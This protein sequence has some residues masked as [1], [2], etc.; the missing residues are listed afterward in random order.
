[1]RTIRIGIVGQYQSG[2]SLL[3][4]CLL[5]RSIASV[6]NGTPTTH[7]IVH[8]IYSDDEYVEFTDI[9][10]LI[11]KKS[12]SSLLDIDNNN[13]ICNPHLWGIVGFSNEWGRTSDATFEI[14][15]GDWLVLRGYHIAENGEF[16][17]RVN[18]DWESNYGANCDS[19]SLCVS[20]HQIYT[21]VP[22]GKNLSVSSHGYYDVYFNKITHEL[23]INRAE[24]APVIKIVNVY[25]NNPL[26]V[27]FELIDMPGFGNDNYDNIHA[28]KALKSIDCAI[29][30]ASNYK[31]I[32]VS[33][34]AFHDF[35]MLQQ[36]NIPYYFFLN[37]TDFLIADK[38]MPKSTIN[39]DMAN[40]YFRLTSYYKPINFT[41][42]E[43]QM[44]I[45]NLM[46]YW[47][48]ISYNRDEVLQREEIQNAIRIYQLEK[49]T[50]NDVRKASQ[51]ELIEKIFGMD[52]KMYLELKRELKE[53]I[54]KLKNEVCPVGTIQAFAF[55]R[56]PNGWMICDGRSLDPKVHNELFLAIGTTF[57]G[58]G[59]ISFVIPDLRGRFVRGWN[60]G[61]G[62]ND[63]D[64]QF[65]SLQE[66]ALQKHI[67]SFDTTKLS[68]SAGGRH[69]HPLWCDE[70]NTVI[71]VTGLAGYNEAKRMCYPTTSVSAG[72]KKTDLGPSAGEHNHLITVSDYPI[73]EP[74]SYD[75][76]V[77]LAS[78]NRPTNI[79]LLYCIKVGLQD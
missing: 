40:D 44:P 34:P 52:N 35:C 5:G 66:D 12:I 72:S 27:N 38:W 23:C 33:S 69:Y 22:N 53:E 63:K 54:A 67:H 62:N 46:W 20:E 13:E 18:N 21:M 31:T 43:W 41:I 50:K 57:G 8:Y 39:S 48:S 60:S 26:L 76:N 64:R 56:I 68:I 19:E 77:R 70:Y 73:G 55:N 61:D 15:H 4:N 11:S 51:F 78:E 75:E 24:S 32:G 25:L 47:Y 6:G 65:G 10:G 58:D 49:Y 59:E 42:Y 37:C 79:A 36:Y 74:S 1:M 7:S 2:K 9:L 16:K 30:I 45:V 17:L 28:I 29:V 14:H 71:S 3:I